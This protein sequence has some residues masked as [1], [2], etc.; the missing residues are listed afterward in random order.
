MS[1]FSTI[2]HLRKELNTI[3]HEI[4]HRILRGQPYQ[5]LA[6]KHKNI[7]TKIE[8]IWSQMNFARAF[9]FLSLL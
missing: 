2:S 3:N 1:K 8:S 6:E 7:V 5:R 4:D 9:R